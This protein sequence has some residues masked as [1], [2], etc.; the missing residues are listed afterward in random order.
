MEGTFVIMNGLV[1]I[2]EHIRSESDAECQEIARAA[3]EQRSRIRA[4]YSRMEQEEYWKS[5]NTGTKE[6]ELRL[7]Q[8][9]SLAAL[10]AKKQLQSA[11]QEMLDKAFK[12]A[13][14]KLELLPKGE[15]ESILAR[16][17]QEAGC[18]APDL[19]EL[20]KDR[21]SKNVMSALFDEGR[22]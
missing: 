15:Y 19:V 17:V 22:L 2:I 9:R 13:A 10:E 11:Q 21:L 3:E 12:L 16:L 6:T 20:Y 18:S 1:K 5:I 14:D 8:L 7:E 4:D